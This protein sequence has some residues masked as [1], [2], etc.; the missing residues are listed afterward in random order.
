MGIRH[1]LQRIFRHAPKQVQQS[2]GERHERQNTINDEAHDDSYDL[3]AADVPLSDRRRDRFQ[4][5]PFA[6]RIAQT[7]R[8]RRDPGSLVIGIYGAW[9][10]GKSTL[11]NF[12]EEELKDDQGTIIVWFNPWRYRDEETML[13][14]FYENLADS[15]R[16]KLTSHKEQAGALLEKYGGLAPKVGLP[17]D[18]QVDLAS[19]A[20][21][22]GG[23]LSSVELQDLKERLEGILSSEGKR[24]VILIDDID[25]LD[26]QDIRTLFRIVKLSAG[27]AYTT[28]VLAFDPNVVAESLGEQYGKGDIDA[29]RNFLEKIVQV[30]LHLPAID[31]IA[32][33]DMCFDGVNQAL[34]TSSVE[35]T[36]EQAQMFSST[37]QEV[38]SVC[39]T[40]PRMAL[41]YGNV[42]LF[43]MPIMRG[44]VDP[45]DQMLVEAMRVF[46]PAL[47]EAVRD[48]P[49]TFL[50][51]AVDT[52]VRTED[53]KASGRK[54]IDDAI[55][56]F[57][58][59]ER[60]AAIELLSFLFP[61]SKMYFSNASYGRDWLD[62]AARSKRVAS[63]HY[64]PRYFSYAVLDDDISDQEIDRI[65]GEARV[66]PLDAVSEAIR[67][68]ITRRNVARFLAKLRMREDSLDP[69]QSQTI[70]LALA[71]CGELFPRNQWVQSFSTVSEAAGILIARLL[72]RQA[73]GGPRVALA[74][75]IVETGSPIGF[76]AECYRWI[77]A[78]A[79]D[80]PTRGR[81]GSGISPAQ[82][83]DLGRRLAQRIAKDAAREPPYISAPTYAQTVFQVWSRWGS[84]DETNAYLTKRFAEHPEEA[85]D[86]LRC[87]LGIAVSGGISRP[88]DFERNEYEA[89]RRVV[90]PI[91]I[92]TALDQ[93]SAEIT[94]RSKAEAA[95]DSS[96]ST[97]ELT[98]Q[99]HEVH[100]MAQDEPPGPDENTRGPQESEVSNDDE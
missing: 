60:N 36:A 16:R 81:V 52:S 70:T 78:D 92:A 35:L 31:S 1:S 44:E 39:L 45:V 27:F 6:Q 50:G 18:A 65:T 69:T 73:S 100:R 13:R 62:D 11:L 75:Q 88:A 84:R 43:A 40:T 2:D 48:N 77:Q 21:A 37:F 20:R 7:I 47:Y 14:N 26:R 5:W 93:G 63:D 12:I 98:C 33:L 79:K 96:L 56:T 49:S 25:R 94:T 4:R 59:R 54:I 72:R 10:D 53:V 8:A 61:R 86:F 80:D 41:R 99:F 57:T 89:V 23:I 74:V 76:A 64:F 34:K 71:Q 46:F 17:G 29:G 91:V 66:M 30:P 87:F 58:D 51:T 3:Y 67:H 83:D 24:I 68:L 9:G 82:L 42:L 28:Y 55:N 90:D 97:A 32:L 95:S 15:L 19:S 38:A 22:L 85:I